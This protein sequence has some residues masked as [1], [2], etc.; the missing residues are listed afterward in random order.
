LSAQLKLNVDLSN[1]QAAITALGKSF[2]KINIGGKLGQEIEK[3]LKEV[4]KQIEEISKKDIDLKTATPEAAREYHKDLKNVEESQK[5]INDLIRQQT[6]N[7][8][9]QKGTSSEIIRDIERKVKSQ[10]I[11]VRSAE[12]ELVTAQR[13]ADAARAGAE[14]DQRTVAIREGMVQAQQRLLQSETA[15]A[16]Q[17]KNAQKIIEESNR[18]LEESRKRVEAREKAEQRVNEVLDKRQKAEEKLSYQQERLVDIQEQVK[19]HQQVEQSVEKVAE[20]HKRNTEE[21]RENV[22]VVTK[23]AQAKRQSL[24]SVS[25][26]VGH[27]TDKMKR[28]VEFTIAAFAL[29][30]LRQ[31]AQEGLRFI[32]ELDKSLTEIATVTGRSRDE[33][34]K[35]ADEFNRMGRELGKTTNEIT[36]ASVLFYRQGLET[37]Q[38]LEMVRAS[39]ISAAIANTNAEEA[40]NRLTAALRGYNL[41]ASDAMTISDKI[42]ALAA[43]SASS[44]DELSYAM[45]K[46]AASAAV[47]GI[48][49]DHL[50]AFLAKVIETTREA[51]EN[52]G[53]AFKTIIAR[54]AQIKEAGEVVE[55]G[56]VTPL[57]KV[58]EALRS[59][60]VALTDHEGQIRDMQ[61][62]F[63]ELGAIWDD[64]DRNTKSYLATIM[65]GSRQQSRFL[66]LMNNYNRT[67]QLVAVAQNSA[68]EA[69]RQFQTHLTGLEAS[70][71][72]LTA[73]KEDFM[74]RLIDHNAYKGVIDAMRTLLD[75][76]SGMHP[77]LVLLIAG[78]TLYITKLVL[79]AAA[80]QAKSAAQAAGNKIGLASY[81]RQQLE[82]TGEVTF[83]KVVK[84]SAMALKSKAA[85][86]GVSM[87]AMAPYLIVLAAVAGAIYALGYHSSKAKREIETMQEQIGT[88]QEES[89]VIER[90]ADQLKGLINEQENLLSKLVLTREESARL[91]EINRELITSFGDIG[92]TVDALGNVSFPNLVKHLEESAE[93]VK[94]LNIRTLELESTLANLELNVKFDEIEKEAG[95]D[96]GSKTK[97][98]W[99]GDGLKGFSQMAFTPTAII[100]T[101]YKQFSDD[102]EDQLDL[103]SQR[104]QQFKSEFVSKLI[105][106]E[107][108]LHVLKQ[109]YDQFGRALVDAMLKGISNNFKEEL[110]MAQTEEEFKIVINRMNQSFNQA[111]QNFDFNIQGTGVTETMFQ[112]YIQR[113]NNDID[114]LAQQDV[115]I[116][117]LANSLDNLYSALANV[118]VE[119]EIALRF[120]S[121]DV[122]FQAAQAFNTLENEIGM[123]ANSLEH[124]SAIEF[125]G[126]VDYIEE[127]EWTF[128]ENQKQIED[129]IITYN[130]LKETIPDLGNKIR[131]LQHLLD[132][133][134]IHL[135]NQTL[136]E[137]GEEAGLTQEQ[138][139]LL[140]DTHG[141]YKPILTDVN[142]I[143]RE[144][145]EHQK[146]HFENSKELFGIKQ[147]L[148]DTGYLEFDQ[149]LHLI[150]AYNLS[151]DAFEINNGILTVRIDAIDDLMGKEGEYLDFKMEEQAAMIELAKSRLEL[152]KQAIEHLLKIA[153]NEAT[154]REELL[155]HEIAIEKIRNNVQVESLKAAYEMAEAEMQLRAD[156]LNEKEKISNAE[157][158]MVAEA[159][160]NMIKINKEGESAFVNTLANRESAL[161]NWAS[162]FKKWVEYIADLVKWHLLSIGGRLVVSLTGNSAIIEWLQDYLGPKPTAPGT[163]DISAGFT[164][165]TTTIN[166]DLV[167][168]EFD[169]TSF[170]NR[171]NEI[172]EQLK[173]LDFLLDNLDKFNFDNLLDSLKDIGDSGKDTA[174]KAKKIKDALKDAAEEIEEYT[175]KL[176]MWYNV[177]RQILVLERE[178]SVVRK[179]RQLMTDTDDILMSLEKEIELLKQLEAQQI[180]RQDLL[181][182][183]LEKTA[184]ALMAAAGSAVTLS[185]DLQHLHVNQEEFLKLST[186]QKQIVDDLIHR[187]DDLSSSIHDTTEAILDLQIQMRQLQL[188]AADALINAIKKAIQQQQ[189]LIIAAIDHEIKETRKAHQEKMKMYDEEL[190]AIHKIIDAKIKS[191]EEEWREEDFR[192]DLESAQEEELRLR[193]EINKL[194]L[195]D[196][197]EAQA[198]RAELEAQ[199]ADQVNKIEKMKK[200]YER[201]L[202]K[203]E[204]QELKDFYKEETEAKKSAEEEKLNT[205]ISA[206]EK[207]KEEINYYYQEILND[208][209]FWAEL[210]VQILEGNFEKVAEMVD[211]L[212]H[213]FGDVAGGI[214]AIAEKY[215]IE[216]KYLDEL[217]VD[218]V[219]NGIQA[220][221]E[222]WNSTK[223]IMDAVS[224]AQQRA[225]TITNALAKAVSAMT[226]QVL[227]QIKS[228]QAAQ[229]A[230]AASSAAQSTT[231]DSVF[232]HTT[233]SPTSSTPKTSTNT[234]VAPKTSTGPT[235]YQLGYAR[236]YDDGY[237]GSGPRHVYNQSPG[238]QSGYS[239]GYKA[240]VAA[241]PS[242]TFKSTIHKG[243]IAGASYH[244]GGI[245]RANRQQYHGNYAKIPGG[246]NNE[247]S[248]LVNDLFQTQNNEIVAKLLKGEVVIN[249]RESIDNLK[250]NIKA[251]VENINPQTAGKGIS[252]APPAK[253]IQLNVN[254]DNMVA[255]NKEHVNKVFTEIQRQLNKAGVI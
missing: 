124:L 10:E 219:Q 237:S 164:N 99:F 198:K 122:A 244:S 106:R 239:A 93:K 32:A 43:K 221:G 113:L 5:R 79:S 226:A 4:R 54:I 156:A 18:I 128:S 247:L 115:N 176:D 131:E 212:Q 167:G 208:E 205:L 89:T 75:L 223:G 251:F 64:L 234:Y 246:D 146:E 231:P 220:L 181:Q 120:F 150:D 82:I 199:L 202:R 178:L 126:I 22:D 211:S 154:T 26:T 14:A 160:N 143:L 207:A 232:S 243:G 175:A 242:S 235:D 136:K 121:S 104:I 42:A 31:F 227:N 34:W 78:L 169:A 91:D 7:Y 125:I 118:G 70:M 197:Q 29:R 59:V 50:Y 183:E 73:A 137:M 171:L 33:M 170:E 35:M 159:E 255:D 142:A 51:P 52:I 206:L 201:D 174:E 24:D 100:R 98:L 147:Q 3:S 112:D 111:L 40:S 74:M 127:M 252:T 214:H 249:P 116:S 37:N 162:N 8:L 90:Q 225:I 80:V 168:G 209:A 38:V 87:L 107:T 61:H 114:S 228:I 110:D 238:Y 158:K 248:K 72:R 53:T 180:Q 96:W 105:L 19:A 200:D 6:E 20:A 233:T 25:A 16:E 166:W 66:A 84:A 193:Q 191:L 85:A 222:S 58:D 241:R 254:V 69:S 153:K 236:G 97:D 135:Y 76:F 163:G 83:A 152:E 184:I 41:A 186:G 65:A 39:T 182:N 179:E 144:T 117:I 81:L 177:L 67:T 2:D 132:V 56:V 94:E 17:K 213:F 71:V 216:L 172:N 229:K 149:M 102:Y 187:F 139:R 210:R 138:L 95:L 47:A 48:D 77:M 57:N 253:H 28:L 140:I 103:Q 204:L 133:G 63:N 109:E 130:Q 250:S 123:T 86:I 119:G 224:E 148:L 189:K 92:Y 245:A 145:I 101:L 188:Q 12:Q 215:G 9:Q 161:W 68:G 88:L 23:G 11:A 60:G 151:A 46:T 21:A 240:G 157:G 230:A 203:R 134:A 49:V 44:F 196:S 173:A 27:L 218:G 13:L 194:A 195:D 108:E 1:A 165:I 15:T 36:R 129:T 217:F 62:I 45:T 190:K 55:D 192:E 30:R 141:E 185:D 155:K